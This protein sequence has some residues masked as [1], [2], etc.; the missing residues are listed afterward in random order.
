MKNCLIEG[1][2]NM[3]ETILVEPGGELIMEDCEI[4]DGFKAITLTDGGVY[5]LK[6]NTFTNNFITFYAEGSGIEESSVS[7]SDIKGNLIQ[8]DNNKPFLSAAGMS[9]DPLYFDFGGKSYAGLYAT[10]TKLDF[11]KFPFYTDTDVNHFTNLH[12][13]MVADQ[14]DLSVS[15]SRFSNIL[16]TIGTLEDEGAALYNKNNSILRFSGGYLNLSEKQFTN[17]K[18]G[19][20]SRDGVISTLARSKMDNCTYGAFL[21]NTLLL[22]RVLSNEILNAEVGVRVI[23]ANRVSQNVGISRNTI[24]ASRKGFWV[25]GLSASITGNEILVDAT[26]ETD[27]AGTAGISYHAP[28]LGDTE[29]DH[30]LHKPRIISNRIKT[31][32]AR[33]GILIN[34]GDGFHILDNRIKFSSGSAFSQ[35][36]AVYGIYSDG[37]QEHQIRTNCISQTTPSSEYSL[38]AE[39]LFIR[40]GKGTTLRCSQ[41]DWIDEPSKAHLLFSGGLPQTDF[42]GN[43]M[44]EFI[45]NP[46]TPSTPG[47]DMLLGTDQNGRAFIGEQFFRGNMWAYLSGPPSSYFRALHLGGEEIDYINSRISIDKT[48]NTNASYQGIVPLE[49]EAQPTGGN[50]QWFNYT[51][52]PISQTQFYCSQDPVCERTGVGS[53]V[54]DPGNVDIAEPIV[55]DLLP[56]NWNKLNRDIVYGN[57]SLDLSV[58]SFTYNGRR[59]LYEQIQYGQNRQIA[60]GLD[61]ATAHWGSEDFAVLA[62][63]RHNLSADLYAEDK[64]LMQ[65]V[66]PNELALDSIVLD[67]IILDSTAFA[68][69]EN[70]QSAREGVWQQFKSASEG[71]SGE[72]PAANLEAT[73]NQAMAQFALGDSIESQ[74][75]ALIAI[76]SDCGMTE[77]GAVYEARALINGNLD[78]VFVEL[79]P[80][81]VPDTTLVR[82][83]EVKEKANY[84]SRVFPNPTS[85]EITIELDKSWE[86][87][88]V[89]VFDGQGRLLWTRESVTSGSSHQIS[90]T[91]QAGSY[92]LMLLNTDK[93]SDYEVLPLIIQR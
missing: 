28:R 8:T 50:Y 51:S 29:P 7:F 27:L 53:T 34:G 68:L 88:D 78:S 65:W 83:M 49:F 12:F 43:R 52:I 18:Y 90:N 54:F 5:K 81:A 75:D 74:L 60:Y 47:S 41:F 3:W 40:D 84:A 58:Y 59:Y 42:A 91:L 61:T 72:N 11:M 23:D 67:S 21:E 62:D 1:C 46:F 19:L 10:K 66:N 80:C 6:N 20:L 32:P 24:E 36:T 63:L 4:R 9:G 86:R 57:D 87:A 45:G 14:A 82:G 15:T 70:V 16:N 38:N 25:S 48:L 2:S 13:G 55:S 77:G 76:A 85:G 37:G 64:A 26:N 39:G 92:F 30:S 35:T 22:G 17:C 31:S 33:H 69:L 73:V 44:I 93:S 79:N 71:F 89:Y 56:L